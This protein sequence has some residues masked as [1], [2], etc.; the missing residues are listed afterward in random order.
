MNQ[1]TLKIIALISMIIDHF[2]MTVVY[3]LVKNGNRQYLDLYYGLRYVGRMAFPIYLFMLSESFM[4]T[5]SRLKYIRNLAIFAIISEPF[6]NYA[7][8]HGSWIY[9]K[10]QNTF[11]TLLIGAVGLVIFEYIES[12]TIYDYTLRYVLWSISGLLLT[13][14]SYFLRT[15]YKGSGVL[16]L[17]VM[18]FV[19]KMLSQEQISR[20]LLNVIKMSAG[21]LILSTSA[22]SKSEWYSFLAVCV[23]VFYSGARGNYR[24]KYFYY[25]IYPVHLL[26]FG[27]IAGRIVL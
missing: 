13:L 11:F 19:G 18:Y 22:V 26:V 21:C 2:G 10:H 24:Y 12:H 4:Y 15:D 5:R 14:L 20:N 8:G 1:R 7:A 3:M 16:A 17:F 27:Y 9:A 6:F 23:I 25:W